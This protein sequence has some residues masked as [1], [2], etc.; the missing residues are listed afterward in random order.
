MANAAK[1]QVSGSHDA[2][3]ATAHVDTFARQHLPPP[4]LWPEFIF[5]RPELHYPP[6]L[7]CVSY[8]LDRWVE[9]G[10][11]DA[12]CVISPTV[13]YTY[14]GLQTLVNRIA[15]VLVDKLGLVTGQRV[16]LRSANSPAP[17]SRR[18]PG[19]Y[20]LRARNAPSAG[21]LAVAPLPK[22]PSVA[23]SGKLAACRTGSPPAMR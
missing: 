14:R 22:S 2:N 1:V 3:T 23:G 6:R 15:N 8:F 11:G 19:R 5:T 18:G 9:R 16:L 10:Q 4:D 21:M 12:P 13:S 20:S 17:G 7:N